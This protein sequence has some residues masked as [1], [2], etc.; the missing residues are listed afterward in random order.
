MNEVKFSS[1][2]IYCR[3]CFVIRERGNGSDG[4]KKDN[5]AKLLNFAVWVYF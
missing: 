5:A 3:F 2:V 1:P 4:A